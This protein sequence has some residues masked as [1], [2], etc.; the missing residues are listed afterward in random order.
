[1]SLTARILVLSLVTGFALG[2]SHTPSPQ[3]SP[4]PSIPPNAVDSKTTSKVPLSQ[5]EEVPAA[6]TKTSPAP[7]SKG[8]L[9]ILSDTMGVDFRP[10]ISRIKTP[11]HRH[12]LEIMP[13]AAMPP[14]MKSGTVVVRFAILKDGKVADLRVEEKS[15]DVALDRAAYGAVSYSTPLPA[16]PRQFGGDYLIIRARFLY[17]PDAQAKRDAE[18]KPESPQK[19]KTD[20]PKD[21][22]HP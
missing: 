2:Q 12:W 16:L 20:T 13:Q 17:N 5:V 9:E 19:A 4:T 6:S 8:S 1:M 21:S 22:S 7:T 11:I 18:K 10:Y 15:G 14:E 3:P